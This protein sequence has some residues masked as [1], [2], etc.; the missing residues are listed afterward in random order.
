MQSKRLSI[1]YC[2][3]FNTLQYCRYR[4]V[5]VAQHFLV[6]DARKL[7]FYI[8]VQYNNRRDGALVQRSLHREKLLLLQC[9]ETENILRAWDARYLVIIIIIIRINNK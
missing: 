1:L 8:Q 4:R 9:N 7:H 3:W 5:C 6:N 2:S